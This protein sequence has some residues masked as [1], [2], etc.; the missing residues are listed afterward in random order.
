VIP[1]SNQHIAPALWPANEPVRPPDRDQ[2]QHRAARDVDQVL[3]EQV[4]AQ[5]D[6]LALEPEQR[7]MR[8]LAVET[9]ERRVEAGD[10]LLR[11]AARGRQEADLRLARPSQLEQMARDRELARPGSELVAAKR[12]DPGRSQPIAPFPVA[13]L[14]GHRQ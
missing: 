5:V 9:L 3:G 11:V 2:V 14:D 13:H 10:A 6:A 1:S 12:D 7:D 4:P 8:G